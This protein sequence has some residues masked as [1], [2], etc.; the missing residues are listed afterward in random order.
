MI[1][2]NLNNS[3]DN[4]YNA[5]AKPSDDSFVLYFHNNEL[6]C[7]AEGNVAS[8]ETAIP[9]KAGSEK[10]V[11]RLLT[12]GEIRENINTTENKLIYLFKMDIDGENREFFLLADDSLLKGTGLAYSSIKDRENSGNSESGDYS[13]DGLYYIPASN[14]RSLVPLSTS[15]AV[16]TAWQLYSWY[17]DNRYCGRCGAL[18]IHDN[19][20]RM[21]KCPD[22]GN[23]I[24]PK[25]CP[26]VI[27][28]II[29]KGRILLTKYA[30]KGYDRYALVAGFT[31]IGETLEESAAREAYE[32]VGLRLKNITFY[33]SQPWSA[34][35]SLLAGFFAEVD[36]SNEVVLET[37]ELKEGTWFYPEDI[38][39]M[40]EGVS[41]TEEMINHF[42]DRKL[43]ERWYKD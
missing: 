39:Q 17:R 20:E 14:F 23:M 43:D 21:L 4:N 8:L 35:S 34:S 15:F 27:V 12:L 41:L 24:Y 11:W 10:V 32:E 42:A 2:D 9:G 25:I 3:Y 29:H 7:H 5:E 36:G 37:E 19:K 18:T 13:T 22:C 33:K 38:V 26:G 6:L 30:N 31:E 16:I 28:G 1:Q 40:H